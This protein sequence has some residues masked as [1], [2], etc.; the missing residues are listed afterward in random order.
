MPE[1]TQQNVFEGIVF[2]AG[3]KDGGKYT[4]LQVSI[5]YTPTGDFRT[6]RAALSEAIIE[7]NSELDILE[8]SVVSA[9]DK[10]KWLSSFFL[11]LRL[12]GGK[13]APVESVFQGCKK[14][15][16]GGPYADI[17][18]MK[19]SEAKKDQRLK[20]SGDFQ[21][22]EFCDH[23]FPKTPRTAFYDWIYC[24]ALFQS[25]NRGLLE[26]V[27][28]H[29]AFSDVM[30]Y[31]AHSLNS[32]AGALARISTLL[33][34]ELI[35]TRLVTF[36]EFV[37]AGETAGFYK[38]F[39]PEQERVLMK[40]FDEIP[41][42]K[43]EEPSKTVSAPESTAIKQEAPARKGTSKKDLGPVNYEEGE[44]TLD[45]EL[46]TPENKP[47]KGKEAKSDDVPATTSDNS[48]PAPKKTSRTTAKRTANQRPDNGGPSR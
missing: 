28:K 29:S 3:N 41:L 16:D 23:K 21:G 36:D 46:S 22:F 15:K 7:K 24:C 4:E 37:K 11:K 18:S 13:L 9:E 30:Y 35:G 38:K 34:M 27:R 32:P 33:N 48:S 20:N 1:N 17:M 2:V 10:G 43:T 31:P 14:F 8:T 5:P 44:A 19:P 6:D 26:E 42:E 47:Q 39:T 25:Q 40:E 45:F 12:P